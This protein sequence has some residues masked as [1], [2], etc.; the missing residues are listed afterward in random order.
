MEKKLAPDGSIF[1]KEKEKEYRRIVGGLAWPGVK[2]GFAVVVA[3][4][5]EDPTSRLRPYYVLGEAEERGMA[6]LFLKCLLLGMRWKVEE[7]YGQADNIP[8]MTIISQL[9]EQVSRRGMKGEI[10]IQYAPF[11]EMP[12]C[13]R[14]LTDLLYGRTNSKSLIIGDDKLLSVYLFNL[15]HE[16]RVSASPEDFPAIAALGFAVA[17]LEA[18][19]PAPPGPFPEKY[20]TE[21]DMFEDI[22][23]E[24]FGR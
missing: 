10:N 23:E 21:F 1:Y 2:P 9:R 22:G 11:I 15:R 7:W 14:Y 6:E 13:F 5:L 4:G 17:Y 8:M 19:D 20:G 3:E 18:Y 12:D 24:R 16:E